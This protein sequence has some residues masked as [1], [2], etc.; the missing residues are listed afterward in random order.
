MGV[1]KGF[2]SGLSCPSDKVDVDMVENCGGLGV[3]N[4]GYGR[5]CRWVRVGSPLLEGV[6][7]LH[8]GATSRQA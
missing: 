7:I 6:A 8:F 4:R 2:P 1:R 5:T 3:M